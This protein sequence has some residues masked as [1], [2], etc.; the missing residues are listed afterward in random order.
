MVSGK[1]IIGSNWGGNTDFM[2]CDNSL[3]ING[4]I[5]RCPMNYSY[6]KSNIFGEMF[7]PNNEDA[8]LKLRQAVDQYDTLLQTFYPQM[9]T[10]KQNYTWNNVAKQIIDLYNKVK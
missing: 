4:K 5:V 1:L 8:S 2:K 7:E 3:L 6:W 10:V 9:Q